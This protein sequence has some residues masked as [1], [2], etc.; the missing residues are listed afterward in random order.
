MSD[1]EL[2]RPDVVAGKYVAALF[3]PSG[4]VLLVN[5]IFYSIQGEGGEAGTAQV[6]VR[7]AKCNLA[8]KFCDTEF[9][10]YTRQTVDEIVARI[11]ALGGDCRA[12]N[13]TGGE[14]ALQNC[15]PLVAALTTLGYMV[16]METSGS[17]WSSWMK[18]VKV[19]CSPK[20]PKA[21]IAIPFKHIAQVKWVMNAAFLLQHSR[22]P[23]DVFIEG[24][25]N[26]LQPESNLPKYI[27]AACKLIM[28]SPGRYR[29]SLQQHKI[30]GV[31]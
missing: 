28:T 20:V 2:F 16:Y 15:G 8:C 30:A 21:R 29:L 22:R 24:V 31:P 23:D 18:W 12:V 10:A 5:E 3:D 27:T 25:P 26:F 13:L 11:A 9:E 19:T 14:P 6:F 7:L 4:T 1:Q 17:V